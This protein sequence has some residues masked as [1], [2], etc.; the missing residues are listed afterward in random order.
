MNEILLLINEWDPIGL[1]PIAP[2]NE[3]MPEV[4]EINK[5]LASSEWDKEKLGREINMLFLRKFGSD[6]YVENLP[7]CIELAEKILCNSSIFYSYLSDFFRNVLMVDVKHYDSVISF[8]DLVL[9]RG[10]F[11]DILQLISKDISYG[12]EVS[13]Y[14]LPANFENENEEGYF[15]NGVMFYLNDEEIWMDDAMFIRCLEFVG[16]IYFKVGHT[17]EEKEMFHHSMALIREKRT[18]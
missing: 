1:F 10:D 16:E 18:I 8:F 12:S 5:M 9:R 15:E 3:Y 14:F 11:L 4:I 6:V 17:A 7:K 2:S 13:G